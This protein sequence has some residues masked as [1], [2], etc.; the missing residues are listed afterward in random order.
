MPFTYDHLPSPPILVIVFSEGKRVSTVS[1]PLSAK[2]S[3]LLLYVLLKTVLFPSVS[4]SS[5]PCRS[6]DFLKDASLDVI[7][8]NT[9]I[10]AGTSLFSRL[11]KM[12]DLL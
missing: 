12:K 7:L 5:R 4:G 11:K 1:F 2:L 6:H 8:S 9:T 10:A 3:T